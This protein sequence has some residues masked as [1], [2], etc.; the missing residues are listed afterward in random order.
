[1]AG[2]VARK[3][4]QRGAHRFLCGV[5]GGRHRRRREDTIKME[6]QELVWGGID[7]IDL[8]QYWYRWRALVNAVMNFRDP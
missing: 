2:H 5:I 4:D 3:G 7:C 6:L 1:M 8:A